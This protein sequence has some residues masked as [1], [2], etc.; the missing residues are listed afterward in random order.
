[1]IEADGSI[2]KF[3]VDRPGEPAA[4]E[5]LWPTLEDAQ[6]IKARREKLH[7]G[8][9]EINRV[10]IFEKTHGTICA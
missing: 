8:I 1:M 9:W 2:V 10:V 5:I 7:G 6:E 4:C 3:S